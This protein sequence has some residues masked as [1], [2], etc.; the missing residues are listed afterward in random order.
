MIVGLTGGIGSGKSTVGKI[1]ETLGY[2][3]FN[4][5]FE[6]KNILQANAEV[7]KRIIAKFGD[8]S[9]F[10]EKPNRK[11]I[12]QKVFNNPENLKFLNGLIHPAVGKRFEEWL[13][14]YKD[15]SICLKEAAI[16]VETG[17]YKNLDKLIL[18][19][20]D[21]DIRI[22]RV[23]DRDDT[24]R[25]EVLKRMKNQWSDEEKIPLADYIIDNSGRQSV[26]HQ[27]IKI[28]KDIGED[29]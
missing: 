25:E 16:L 29:F 10:G 5:D 13:N 26:I 15:S 28:L 21:E 19:K 6:A 11:F 1:F 14:D 9:F 22:Q 17:S 8:D 4:S 7:R 24:T 2:P 12:A 20:A 23:L 18:V 3:V 27:V